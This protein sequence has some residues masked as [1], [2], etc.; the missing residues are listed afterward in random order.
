MW[1]LIENFNCL[2]QTFKIGRWLKV[3]LG[4]ITR[5]QSN[6]SDLTTWPLLWFQMLAS[7]ESKIFQVEK[8]VCAH[9]KLPIDKSLS[10]TSMKKEKK[11]TEIVYTCAKKNLNLWECKKRSLQFWQSSSPKP[12]LWVKFRN[13]DISSLSR[14]NCKFPTSQTVQNSEIQNLKYS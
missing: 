1:Y 4:I 2:S 6:R 8:F 12:N 10:W 7:R 5:R 14:L 13:L 3:N 9:E 11:E